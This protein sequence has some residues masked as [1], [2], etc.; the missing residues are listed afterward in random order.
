LGSISTDERT[1]SILTTP[2]TLVYFGIAFALIFI[3][4]EPNL[5]F[6][7]VSGIIVIPIPTLYVLSSITGQ[8]IYGLISVAVAIF[9]SAVLTMVAT[10]IFNRDIVILGLKLSLRK[11]RS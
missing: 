8:L 10:Y 6:A 9:L 4:M 7:I 11:T 3:G 1:A 2:I 5:S